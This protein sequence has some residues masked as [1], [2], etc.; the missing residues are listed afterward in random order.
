AADRDARARCT[1]WSWDGVPGN[2][3]GARAAGHLGT[4]EA[5]KTAVEFSLGMRPPG[6]CTLIEHPNK[7]AKPALHLVRTT[8]LELRQA[9]VASPHADRGRLGGAARAA[10]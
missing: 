3:R 7:P 8:L 10:V 6:S 2:Y 5:L 9:G 4:I 1:R